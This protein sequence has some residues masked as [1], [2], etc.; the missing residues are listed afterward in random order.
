MNVCFTNSFHIFSGKAIKTLH[1]YKCGLANGLCRNFTDAL[2]SLTNEDLLKTIN[3]TSVRYSSTDRLSFLPRNILHSS[4]FRFDRRGDL[5][6]RKDQSL[7]VIHNA[8]CPNR[9][10]FEIVSMIII[11]QLKSSRL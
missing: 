5:A 9:C 1:T 10:S 6:V 2:K 3:S 8:K 11:V 4:G 7:Y